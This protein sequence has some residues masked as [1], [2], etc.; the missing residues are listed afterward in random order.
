[1]F[2]ILLAGSTIWPELAHTHP[3]Q[4]HSS[5]S[6]SSS[7]SSLFSLPPAS[8]IS[9]TSRSTTT[10][11]SK[12]TTTLNSFFTSNTSTTETT[13][14][15]KKTKQS[16]DKN[17]QESFPIHA[18]N[19]NSHQTI[20]FLRRRRRLHRRNANQT[21]VNRNNENSSSSSDQMSR[22][23]VEWRDNRTSS[24]V[25]DNDVSK[26]KTRE[27]NKSFD[28]VLYL[29]KYG[30]LNDVSKT[31]QPKRGSLVMLSTGELQFISF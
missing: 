1:M 22:E 16:I 18:N 10:S 25:V 29:S 9:K 20:N 27:T 2:L 4:L 26:L 13:S 15:H 12:T 21:N 6:S 14:N 30:Y 28:P 24:G 5:S 8:S 7:L 11:T 19:K 23:Q 31:N 3:L 17:H